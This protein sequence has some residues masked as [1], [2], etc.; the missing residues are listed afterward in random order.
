MK[1]FEAKAKILTSPHTLHDPLQG[2]IQE[3]ALQDEDPEQYNH[4]NLSHVLFH[5]HLWHL[6]QPEV[7][8]LDPAK[9]EVQSIKKLK[10]HSQTA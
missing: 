9:H 1:I 4:T 10:L 2:E 6:F 3:H 7:R 5:S 8:F